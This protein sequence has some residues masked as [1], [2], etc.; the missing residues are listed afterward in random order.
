MTGRQSDGSVYNN[1]NLGYAI[2]NN[3]L[4]IPDPERMGNSDKILPYIL[5]ADDAFGLKKHMM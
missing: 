5:V 1:C 3:T 2:E 4:N